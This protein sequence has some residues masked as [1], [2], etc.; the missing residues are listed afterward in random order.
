MKKIFLSPTG[1][2]GRRDFW[3]G[4]IGLCVFI[5]ITNL[6]LAKFP[7]LYV[8][9]W[10]AL[11]FPFLALFLIYSIYGQ[12]LHDLGHSYWPLTMAIVVEVFVV[13]GVMMAFGGAEYF[14]EFSQYERK[15][16]IDPEVRARLIST[17]QDEISRNMHVIRPLMWVVPIVITLFLG[18]KKGQVKEN[19]Y[20]KASNK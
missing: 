2:I 3:I 5:C 10:V 9:F 16:V 20:G 8:S 18:L 14:T 17:Y 11:V 4:F 15:A 12:R 6:Y 7:Q 13:I 1:R 19:K